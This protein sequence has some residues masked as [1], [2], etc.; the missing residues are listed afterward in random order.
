MVYLEYSVTKILVKLLFY[1]GVSKVMVQQ[2]AE[3]E[4]YQYSIFIFWSEDSKFT[5]FHESTDCH[6]V[7]SLY[8]YGN[9]DNYHK[10]G[11]I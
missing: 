6:Q 10:G 2:K 8:L 1:T 4:N 5:E 11:Y 3:Y 7:N 9:C